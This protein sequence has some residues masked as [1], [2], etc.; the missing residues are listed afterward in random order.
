MPLFTHYRSS[1]GISHYQ[2]AATG[3]TH[4]YVW[5]SGVIGVG[6][7]D[8]GFGLYTHKCIPRNTYI[9]CYAPTASLKCTPQN[10]DYAMDLSIGGERISV[11]GKENAYEIGLG[12]YAN[13]GSFPFNIVPEKFSRLVT[14]R[15]NCEFSKRDNEVWIKST[16]DI[17]PNEEL[18]VCYSLDGSYWKSIF[19]QG[20]L[21][22]IRE[23]LLSCGPT[24]RDAEN[25][26]SGLTM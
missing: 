3:E 4:L 25:A 16:R 6:N 21:Q 5:K 15:V 7:V 23:V 10:G 17:R 2:T 20:Q 22:Q 13:D 24:Q 8:T 1:E 18:L 26:F 9:C 11:N 14:V 12:V 19:T